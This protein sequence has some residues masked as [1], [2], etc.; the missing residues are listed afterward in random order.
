MYVLFKKRVLESL[1]HLKMME[2]AILECVCMCCLKETYL[3]CILEGTTCSLYFPL[4]MQMQASF[5]T[6]L[7]I[8]FLI[9]WKMVYQLELLCYT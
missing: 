5:L 8:S 6:F 7:Y 3:V 1:S 4:H 2:I 9:K